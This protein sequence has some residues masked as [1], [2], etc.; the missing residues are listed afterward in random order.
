M[1]P[2]IFT[3]QTF[4]CQNGIQNFISCS[5]NSTVDLHGF[6]NFFEICF[7][8]FF[9]FDS[10]YRLY[11]MLQ[12]MTFVIDQLYR[13]FGQL[14]L[15]FLLMP[16]KLNGFQLFSHTALFKQCTLQIQ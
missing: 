16:E 15:P 4:F 9:I 11:L 13:L 1:N 10:T 6:F 14:I 5:H 2:A 7:P 12:I 3:D 8:L